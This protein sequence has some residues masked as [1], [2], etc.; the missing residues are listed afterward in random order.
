MFS[1]SLT[2]IVYNGQFSKQ[3]GLPDVYYRYR[4]C[5]SNLSGSTPAEQYQRLKQIH[6]TLRVHS[7]LYTS[8]LGSLHTYKKPISDNT[9]GFYGVCWN[10]M[11]DRPIPSVQRVSVPTGYGISTI[12][13]RHTSVTSSKP[14]CQTP[15]GIGCDIKHNSYDR[16]LNRI[17][18]KAPLRRGVVPHHFGNSITFNLANPI[19]GGKTFKTNIIENCGCPPEDVLQ[20]DEVIYHNNSSLP[21]SA[22]PYK[23]KV[24]NYVYAK[25]V[26]HDYFSKAIINAINGNI[27]TIQ[28]TGNGITQTINNINDLLIYFPPKFKRTPVG[29]QFRVGD[30]VYAKK[31]GNEE[32]SKGLIIAINDGDYDKIYTIQFE[33]DNSIENIMDTE[34]IFIY[35]PF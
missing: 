15:G 31:T 1:H 25:Q 12:N 29:Y 30:F 23:F 21:Y 28:F 18:G 7:S 5:N 35:I 2:S 32:F 33:D 11:S 9:N 14:G 8:N 20:Q 3:L 26:G 10:Q 24:G 13:K 16:Y 17:K 34:C 19:Y 4:K 27:Y 22:A 6:N